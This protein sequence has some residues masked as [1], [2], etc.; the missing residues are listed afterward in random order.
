MLIATD[1][2]VVDNSACMT[3]DLKLISQQK[4][5]QEAVVQSIKSVFSGLVDE[6]A[7]TSST[8]EVAKQLYE[9]ISNRFNESITNSGFTKFVEAV[10]EI[11]S[12]YALACSGPPETRP[13][14]EDIPKLMQEFAAAYEEGNSKLLEIRSIYGQM[15]CLGDLLD[16]SQEVNRKRR[17]SSCPERQNCRCPSGGISDSIVCTCE[18][19][20]CL[21]EGD[22]LKPMFLDF[23]SLSCLA[24][25][26]DTT[27]SMKDEV[28]L[29]TDIIRGFLGSE[30]EGGCYLLV[31]FGDDGSGPGSESS[32]NYYRNLLIILENYVYNIMDCMFILLQT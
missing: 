24:F 12:G 15:L 9:S 11:S 29:A 3:E 4:E 18:F 1:L 22:K 10:S 28:N 17:Q 5:S 14:A 19:F 32:K 13:S 7:N 20:D 30:E 27:G 25:V 21:D 31:P 2:P 6:T 23:E 16:L 26:I 8:T